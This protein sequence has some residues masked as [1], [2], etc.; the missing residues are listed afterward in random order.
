MVLKCFAIRDRL[1]SI[2]TAKTKSQSWVMQSKLVGPSAA[3][4]GVFSYAASC[5]SLPCSYK[6]GNPIPADLNVTSKGRG[7]PH[8]PIDR[9]DACNSEPNHVG[10]T[11]SWLFLDLGTCGC[12]VIIDD[13]FKFLIS[14]I[15]HACRYGK[16]SDNK[17]ENCVPS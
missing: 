5:M 11:D 3:K 15:M 6:W 8:L 7:S 13:P 2:A 9:H 4:R 14:P 12:L 1:I 17:L 16:R 10:D